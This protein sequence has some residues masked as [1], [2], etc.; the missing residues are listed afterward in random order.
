MKMS[1]DQL[2][3]LLA[4]LLVGTIRTLLLV[5][6]VIVMMQ[7]V[8]KVQWFPALGPLELLYLAGAFW[9]VK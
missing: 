7:R 3:K 8:G 9:L 2:G 4:S 6:I 5:A 1:V